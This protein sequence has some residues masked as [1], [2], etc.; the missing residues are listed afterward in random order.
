[1]SATFCTWNPATSCNGLLGIHWRTRATGPQISAMAQKS[2]DATL[3]SHTFWA[4]WATAHFGLSAASAGEVAGIMDGIDSFNMPTTT[5]WGP[6][7]MT[8]KKF[9]AGKFDFVDKFGTY[10][11]AVQGPSNQDRFGY[12]LAFFRYFR[13]MAMVEDS[14]NTYN[15]IMSVVSKAPADQQ[16]QLA[17]TQLLPARI[18]LVANV[19]SMMENL[20]TTLSS[21]G[22]LGTYMNIESRS[23]T[24]ILGGANLADLLKFL[25]L[26]SADQL[27]ADAMPPTAYSSTL[28]PRLIV[29]TVRSTAEKGQPLALRALS[30]APTAAQGVIFY[31]KPLGSAALDFTPIKAT[32]VAAGRDVFTVSLPASVTAVDFEWYA[33]VDSGGS[34]AGAVFPAGAPAVTQSVVVD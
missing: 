27:P 18:A 12:W 29:P 33:E 19:T 5:S 1:M 16:Q 26:A 17:K 7:K 21:P 31:T 28:P 24:T 8:P 22:E 34:N 2:W 20:Q 23:V 11:S 4:S 6:G 10:E 9:P 25:K 13:A 32:R 30:L 3:D 15:S 14:W